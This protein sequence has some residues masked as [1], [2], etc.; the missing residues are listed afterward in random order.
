MTADLRADVDPVL[1]RLG[2]ALRFRI[3]PRLPGRLWLA[4]QVP[5]I[6][7]PAL[8]SALA[9]LGIAVATF[10]LRDI[11]CGHVAP[12]GPAPKPEIVPS[13][14]DGRAVVRLATPIAVAFTRV[15]GAA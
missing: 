10:G 7:A 12:C 1:R 6:L 11:D 3:D 13:A 5:S 8:R 14:I 15:S 2:C 9:P 4:Y